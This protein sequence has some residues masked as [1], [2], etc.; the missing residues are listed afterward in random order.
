MSTNLDK[1]SR[2]ETQRP[3]GQVID[4]VPLS[5]HVAA[6]HYVQTIVEKAVEMDAAA[7]VP[8]RHKDVAQSLAL[9]HVAAPC[10]QLLH[11]H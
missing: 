3:L 2:R 1:I 11:H 6:V 9:H 4:L 10:V 5:V 8:F 7:L